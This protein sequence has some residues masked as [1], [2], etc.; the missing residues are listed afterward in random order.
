MSVNF[1]KI[2][3]FKNRVITDPKL[4]SKYDNEFKYI[5][6]QPVIENNWL[7]PE[8]VIQN[9]YTDSRE[10]LNY[11]FNPI[12]VAVNDTDENID[13]PVER[14][15]GRILDGRQ[16]YADS[17]VTGKPWPV[18]YVHIKDY[19]EFLLVMSTMGSK[20]DPIIQAQQTRSIIQLYCELVWKN[21]PREIYGK[22]NLPDRQLVSQYVKTIFGKRWSKR[23]IEKAISKQFKNQF[24][25]HTTKQP[26]EPKPQSKLKREIMLLKQD[27][28]RLMKYTDELERRLLPEEK[29]DELISTQ[30]NRIRQLKITIGLI[31]SDL[32]ES[33]LK[34]GI[35]RT[36]KDF[37][38]YWESLSQEKGAYQQ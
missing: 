21:K 24:Y 9:V 17:K 18:V 6:Y 10:A 16:R 35:D 15:H 25:M 28:D 11:A 2:I 13:N 26:D 33:R 3:D 23:T 19:E 8:I 31:K 22:D 30:D 34:A 27:N 37:K 12:Y 14:V 20:K 29:K 7:D 32:R 36:E 38:Q 1:K 4:I 5:F